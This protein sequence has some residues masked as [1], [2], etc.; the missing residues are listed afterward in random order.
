MVKHI[1][2]WKIKEEKTAEEK[3]K[4]KENVKSYDT[5]VENIE[6]INNT[7]KEER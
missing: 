1:I 5:S 7:E 6:R 2:L 4:I 3:Q